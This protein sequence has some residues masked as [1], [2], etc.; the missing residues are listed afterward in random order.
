MNWLICHHSHQGNHQ[1]S[2]QDWILT[3]SL[4]NL[5]LLNMWGKPLINI[6]SGCWVDC[7]AMTFQKWHK[8]EHIAYF[9]FAAGDI[10]EV[11]DLRYLQL[12]NLDSW[13]KYTKS[14]MKKKHTP[15]P[16][17]LLKILA[18]NF[19]SDID[20]Q[21]PQLLDWKMKGNSP[22]EIKW[23]FHGKIFML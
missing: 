17:F 4:S 12:G 19:H 7:Q 6:V 8:I 5:A 16:L 21:A 11:P 13:W 1:L 3:S 23:C 9:M 10:L 2:C 18:M 22:H 15:N 14:S 20:S